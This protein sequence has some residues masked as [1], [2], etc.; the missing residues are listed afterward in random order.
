MF[1]VLFAEMKLGGFQSEEFGAMRWG[2]EVVKVELERL[3]IPHSFPCPSPAELEIYLPK[4][5]SGEYRSGG[6]MSP[7]QCGAWVLP[8]IF[9]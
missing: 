2:G 3:R 9:F 5:D 4:L 7:Y 6:T 1:S 8:P